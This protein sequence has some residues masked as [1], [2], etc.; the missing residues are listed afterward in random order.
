M[1]Q[2]GYVYRYSTL[3]QKGILVYGY[4][5]GPLWNSPSPILF[6][7]SQCR[8]LVKSGML[9]YFEIDEYLSTIWD[10]QTNLSQKEEEIRVL[11]DRP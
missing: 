4:N 11:R 6:H 5:D 8:S 3:E 7:R 10:L 9:V 2:I 1:K